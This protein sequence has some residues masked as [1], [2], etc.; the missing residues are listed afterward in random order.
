[1]HKRQ[2]FF[3]LPLFSF[4]GTMLILENFSEKAGFYAMNMAEVFLVGVGLSMDAFAVAICKGLSMRK[5]DYH[6]ATVIG[7]YFGGFQALMPMLGFLLGFKFEK[8]IAG[9][10]HCHVK[11]LHTEEYPTPAPRPHYSVLDK[12]KIK[13]AF[14]IEIPWWEDSLKECLDDM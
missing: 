10:D 8:Y 6:Y 13:E 14:D 9:I 7:L 3:C 12:T 4:Y 5:V 2:N 1:M 11:P